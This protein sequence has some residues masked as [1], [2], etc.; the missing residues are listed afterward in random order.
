MKC[1]V[2][3]YIIIKKWKKNG[4]RSIHAAEIVYKMIFNT[5]FCHTNL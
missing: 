2:P 1:V 5:T 4:L 3:L